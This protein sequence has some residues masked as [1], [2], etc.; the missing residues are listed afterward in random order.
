MLVKSKAFRVV[1]LCGRD[2]VESGVTQTT[3]GRYSVRGAVVS[4]GAPQSS[5]WNSRRKESERRFS[6]SI[7]HQHSGLERRFGS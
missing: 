4:D 1:C 6:V 2:V 5:V 3:S 7:N